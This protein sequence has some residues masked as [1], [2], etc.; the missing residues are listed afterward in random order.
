MSELDDGLAAERAAPA[1][2]DRLAVLAS[3]RV[4]D[5]PPEPSF[6]AIVKLAAE[7]CQTPIAAISLV[8]DKRQWFK[9]EIGL[10][11]RET[12][13]VMAVCDDL[14]EAEEAQS[15]EVMS[16]EDLS[17]DPR[18]S[19]NPLVTS[20]PKLRFYAGAPLLTADRLC[21]GML[22]LLDTK[23]RS[24][25]PAQRES[26]RAL[27]AQT[28]AL[29][30]LRRLLAERD[31]ALAQKDLLVRE[32]HHRVKNTLATVQSVMSATARASTTLPEFQDAF[33]G[34]V[35]ALAKTHALLTD[36]DWQSASFE[37]LALA[38]LEPFDDGSAERI[39]LDGPPVI[40]TSDL[41]IPIGM[42]LH[43][44]TSNAA[45]HGALAD[46]KGRLELRWRL[47]C[48]DS[49]ETF[50][51]EWNEHDGPPVRLPTR[52]GFGTRLLDR[53]LTRQLGAEV[54]INYEP[55]G[56]RISVEVPL[57]AAGKQ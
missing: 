57:P 24:L 6:D 17:V 56:L 43:E 10:G 19:A 51:W 48:G 14:I 35:V 26:L 46:P 32:L 15:G 45:K 23:P 49:A 40:L 21:L 20:D 55:D 31:E 7:L 30:E 4:L 29:L 25:T 9:A 41:A 50:C 16:V 12:S 36:H 13:L 1:G 42:A 54:D 2:R 38:E 47:E 52:E 53:V 44:L 37:D 5:T 8:A 33:A 39:L 34:R 27:A 22:C 3:Y 11:V 28:M 18:F